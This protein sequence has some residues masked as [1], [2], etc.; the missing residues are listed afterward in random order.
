MVVLCF[1]RKDNGPTIEEYIKQ[2]KSVWEK[3]WKNSV[4]LSFKD[5]AYN[6]WF[7]LDNKQFTKLSD[8]ELERVLL[9]K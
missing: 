5:E 8:A 1:T 4:W 9:E 3:Y 6:W 7:S 2:K